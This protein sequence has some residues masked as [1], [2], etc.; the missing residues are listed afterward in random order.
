MKFLRQRPEGFG[1]QGDPGRVD[2][3][4]PHLGAEHRT[5]NAQDVPDI[6]LFKRGVGV[7]PHVVPPDIDLHAVAAVPQVEEARLAHDPAAHHPSRHRNGAVFHL[8]KA[9]PDVRVV[10]GDIIFGQRKGILS[11]VPQSRELVS[12]DLDQFRY[13]LFGQFLGFGRSAV[14]FVHRFHILSS[15]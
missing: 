9:G 3:N 4:F 1:E 10:G 11:G 5:F 2:G 6:P 7:L 12:A 13:L 8:V 14:R 15:V